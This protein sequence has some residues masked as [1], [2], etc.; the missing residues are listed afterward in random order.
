VSLFKS[1]YRTALDALARGG[2]AGFAAVGWAVV[3]TFKALK[4]RISRS[5]ARLSPPAV[6]N[7]RVPEGERKNVRWTAPGIDTENSIWAMR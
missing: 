1:Y 3:Q 2:P 7:S 5:F 4:Q 6:W